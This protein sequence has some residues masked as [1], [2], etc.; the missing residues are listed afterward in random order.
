[1]YNSDWLQC[2]RPSPESF[3]MTPD[4]FASVFPKNCGFG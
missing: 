1:M 4:R 3:K 2:V